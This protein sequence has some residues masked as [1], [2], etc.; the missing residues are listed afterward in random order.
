MPTV[1]PFTINGVSTDVAQ[2]EVGQ[3]GFNPGD[4]E[5]GGIEQSI[6]LPTANLTLSAD[7]SFYNASTFSNSYAGEAILL[8]DNKPVATYTAGQIN[9]GQLLSGSLSYSFV[10]NG[11]QATIGLEFVRPAT[12]ISGLTPYQMISVFDLEDPPGDPEA[13]EPGTWLLC[14]AALVALAIWQWKRRAEQAA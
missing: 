14:G 3:S 7:V 9:A 8:I 5:G 11:Q 13:P 10:G 1:V 4:T 6:I 2:F 12:E